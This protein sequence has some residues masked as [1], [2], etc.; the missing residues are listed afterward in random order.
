MQAWLRLTAA[1]AAALAVAHP[2][3]QTAA[4]H[5]Q[6]AAPAVFDA[7]A[8]R[9]LL[10]RYCV[11]CHNARMKTGGLDLASVDAAAPAEHANVFEMVITK[12][13]AGVMPPA[14]QRRPDSTDRL[15]LVRYLETKLDRA[16]E[17]QPNPGRTEAFHRLNRREYQNA[18]RD[19]LGVEL[20][21]A[22]LLPADDASFGFDNIAGV[23]KISQSRLE[24]YLTAARKI[25]RAALGAPLS[26]PA[27]AQY[28]VPETLNQYDRIE[29]LPFGTRGGMQ[30]RHEFP[31]D[32]EYEI[33]AD[34]LCRIHGECDGSVG[35]PDTHTLLVLVDG[36]EVKS[37]TL[38]PRTYLQLRPQGERSWRVRLPLKA[39]PHDVAATFRKLPS[40]RELDSAYARFIRPLYINGS[41]GESPNHTIYQP[42]LDDIA[43]TGPFTSDGPGQSPSRHR[44]LSCYPR[45]ASEDAGC[46]KTILR[47][48]ARRAYRRPVT[49]ADIEPLL[50]VYGP[51]ADETGF[52]SGVETAL[53]RLL[54]SPQFLY[55]IEHDPVGAAP[56][57]N[58]RISDLELAS[59]LSFLL[60][61]SIPDET[62]LSA[63]ERGQL[64][65]PAV[66]DQQVRRMLGD[67]RA[68]ALMENF[69]GQWLWLRNVATHRPDKPLFPDFDDSLR[70]AA[71]RETELLFATVLREDR[72][73]LELLTADYTFVNERL[74]RHYGIPGIYGTEFQRVAIA[75]PNRRGIL[76][77]TSIL[78]VTSRPNRT[79]PVI[80]GKWILENILGTPAPEP[81][82]N[83]PAFKED[84]IGAKAS[85]GT[86]RERMAAHHANPVCAGCH[87][88]LEPPGLALE[89]FDAVGKWRDVDESRRALDASGALPDG[90][91]FDDLNGF[92]ALL[93]RD[94]DVFATTVT[95]KLMTYA[96][97]RGLEPY[98]M[99]AVRQIVRDGTP[100]GLHLSALVAGVVRS[101]PFQMRRKN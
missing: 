10:D 26:M 61:S 92:R 37:F 83:V 70:E 68:D 98:D 97:G 19:L 44:I 45:S 87:A 32:G 62:L 56:G 63:A 24:Q 54:V 16:A 88:M 2:G 30:V 101:V 90:T 76:G 100:A 96:L 5:A 4:A 36:A 78:S 42:F 69:A 85:L 55:R 43:I 23:L 66:L 49:D 8:A 80:R 27:S 72:P 9:T 84:E 50:A 34:L 53:Q 94:P 79:S 20:D 22:P 77:H 65:N 60:W 99:P 15:R 31:R 48:L 81:P 1:V 59:R 41:N 29:G 74:A 73:V 82:P 52:E 18:V 17:T 86:M 64:K 13:R 91:K 58:Y 57:T 51:V 89:N 33:R 11:T 39:G 35:F 28:R 12:L 46:A 40:I 38:E 25:S 7:Q 3:G 95:K 67:P 14:G 71:R 21:V 75:D 6:S 47:T 93:V